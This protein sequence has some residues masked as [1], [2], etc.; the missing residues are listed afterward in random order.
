MRKRPGMGSGYIEGFCTKVSRG[1]GT[2]D[3]E[4]P[5]E[6]IKIDRVFVPTGGEANTNDSD[7]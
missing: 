3:W 7:L 2:W 4:R 5:F 6:Y 1:H